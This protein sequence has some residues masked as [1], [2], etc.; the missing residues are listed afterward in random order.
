[1]CGSSECLICKHE[2]LSSNPSPSHKKKKKV[3]PDTSGLYYTCNP[4]YLG[5]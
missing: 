2:A 1:M 3:L 5:G 4:S